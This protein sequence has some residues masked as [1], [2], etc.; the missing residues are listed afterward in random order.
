MFETHLK[1]IIKSLGIL[2]IV[3][4][5]RFT[6]TAFSQIEGDRVI[7]VVG[8]DIITES[9]LQ[10][11]LQLYARQN[12]LTE[13]PP[14]VAQQVFQSMLTNKII[15]A[16]AE[17]DSVI[18]TEDEVNR[19]LDA[20]VKNLVNQ[21]GSEER[22]EQVY[23]MTLPKIK[24]LIKEDLEK[25][26]KIEKLKRKRFQTGMRITDREVREFYDSYKD[27]IPDVSTEFEV[28]HIFMERKVSDAEKK[29]AKRIA[30][31]I[32]DSIKNGADFSELAR[33][34]SQDS[35]SA[36]VGGDLGY[37][38]RGTFVK[39]FEEAVF[40]LKPGEV[41]NVIE[42]EFGYHIIKL[43]E[44]QGDKVRAQ[45]ILI[46]F[47]RFESSDFETI[48]FLKDL[49]KKIENNEITFEDAAKIYSQDE[50][51]KSKGGYIG[52][53]P[54]EQFDSAA[55]EALKDLSK[56]QITDPLRTGSDEKYGYEIYKLI[57]VIP[58]HK[59]SL[60]GD[61][62]RIKKFAESLKENREIEKW[63]NEIRKSIYVDIRLN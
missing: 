53:I 46:K 11:Q 39:E 13:I 16:K 6:G 31:L 62:E 42:T 5:L 33:R 55:A 3:I 59:L 49:K 2:T 32:L 34:N 23:G 51:T 18:V 37:A 9:D 28:A 48:N 54:I 50:N 8:Y 22:L 36:I 12:Q 19:E 57:D 30:E 4:L 26:L 15:L 60:E 63:I 35:M 17:Q 20:R 52:K 21:V 58:P 61:Y 14:Y 29:E 27:S 24:L 7:A 56:G 45:H 25:S 41:S 10:Y 40:S 47:P 44:K 1:N 38:K 43:N